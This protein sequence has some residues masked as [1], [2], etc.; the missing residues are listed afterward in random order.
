MPAISA[1]IPGKIQSVTVTPNATKVFRSAR[2]SLP[3]R[4]R[5]AVTYSSTPSIRRIS[6][7]LSSSRMVASVRDGG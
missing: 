4:A 1:M 3:S 6:G 2:E 5:S 7:L